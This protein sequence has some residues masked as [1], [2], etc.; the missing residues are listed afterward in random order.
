MY[1]STTLSFSSFQAATRILHLRRIVPCVLVLMVCSLSIIALHVQTHIYVKNKSTTSMRG[2]SNQQ[3]KK[4]K[5]I[6][7]H[8]AIEQN[9]KKKRWRSS[10]LSRPHINYIVGLC[11]CVCV[12]ERTRKKTLTKQPQKEK[13]NE[14]KKSNI[15]CRQNGRHRPTERP[16]TKEQKKKDGVYIYKCLEL[17]QK[18]N[19]KK[20]KERGRKSCTY[21]T[22]IARVRRN[23]RRVFSSML[24]AVVLLLTRARCAYC[25]HH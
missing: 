11:V 20:T 10:V 12:C 9:E 16:T 4:V 7:S 17:R 2:R 23:D 8:F 15:N 22:A 6:R 14:R 1:T 21:T 13:E 19:E 24:L 5:Q 25:H 3:K 18:E